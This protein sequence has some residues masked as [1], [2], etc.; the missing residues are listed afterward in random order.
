[1]HAAR[2][3]LRGSGCTGRRAVAGAAVRAEPAPSGD[4]MPTLT[5]E[6]HSVSTGLG[7]GCPHPNRPPRLIVVSS[8]T[9][10]I[11]GVWD[12]RE[13]SDSHPNRRTRLIVCRHS[14]SKFTAF[15]VVAERAVHDELDARVR[16]RAVT[17]HRN[18]QYFELSRNWLSTPEPALL[19]ERAPVLTLE[20]HSVWS[21]GG[22]S[23]PSRN[24]RRCSSAPMLTVEIHSVSSRRGT[25]CPHLNRHPHSSVCHHSPLK[26]TAFRVSV[27][28]DIHTRTGR[29]VRLRNRTHRGRPDMWISCRRIDSRP[30]VSGR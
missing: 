19:F 16:S 8:L 28:G 26:F 7:L 22:T 11:H 13:S 21:C 3:R 29:L 1:M 4:S 6:F 30:C 15:R 23:C 2:L 25:S 5:V 12:R 24:R 27:G 10:G 17:H 18:S 14:P 9:A 20:I